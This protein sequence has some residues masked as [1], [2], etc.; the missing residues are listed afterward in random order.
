MQKQNIKQGGQCN[1]EYKIIY[2]SGIYGKTKFLAMPTFQRQLAAG[3]RTLGVEAN[4]ALA[5]SGAQ[6]R[7]DVLVN[8][9]EHFQQ[10][11]IVSLGKKFCSGSASDSSCVDVVRLKAPFWPNV[12][13]EFLL[14]SMLRFVVRYCACNASSRLSSTV[15][16]LARA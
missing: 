3:W 13:K 4:K 2:N 7:I 16:G 5:V 8:G 11:H 10:R 15:R 9:R 1:G 6:I 14:S 12:M